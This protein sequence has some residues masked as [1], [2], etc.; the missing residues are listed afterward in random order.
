MYIATVPNRS[1]PPAIL[2]RESHR[3][4]KRVKT[5]TLSNIS[6]WPKEKIEGLRRVLHGE[7]VVSPE[8]AFEIKRSLPHGHVVAVLGTLRRLGLEQL[9][10]RKASRERSLTVSMVVSRIIEPRSKLATA[11]GI[12]EET[13]F[14]SL[15]EELDAAS[16]DENELYLA[17]DWILQSQERIEN[18]L[19]KRHLKSGSLVLYDVT[20]TYF[21]G[22][23]CPLAKLG[24]S[25]DGKKDKLQIVIGLLTNI[26]GC[27]CAVEVFPGNTGDPSTVAAQIRKTK[28]RFLLDRVILVGDRGMIT[29][30]RLQKDFQGVD[31]LDWI[32][33]M[34]SPAIAK[35]FEAGA[36]Q[37]SLFDERDLAEITHPDYP[38]ERLIVCRNPI[39]A[40]ERARK[41][42]DLLAATERTLAKIKKAT[43]RQNRPLRGKDQ[44]ALRVGRDIG[45]YKVQKHFRIKITETSLYYRRKTEKINAEAALDGFYVIRT[46]VPKALLDSE[47]TV[48]SYKRL[49]TVERAFRSLKTVDLKIR[50]IF[51]HTEDR[52]RSHVFICMLAYYVE[53]HMRQMLAPILF[54]DDDKETAEKIRDSIVAPAQRSPRS[55]E[56]AAS[57]RTD[58]DFPV[59]SFQTLIKDLATLTKNQVQAKIDGAPTFI[60]YSTPTRLQQ[61]AFDLLK[62]SPGS[63]RQYG[64]DG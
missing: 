5:K 27:P 43:R 53:W 24:L 45:R 10:D 4:G 14:S 64:A 44:I 20:S 52:V 11:R 47:G 8:D 37:T 49:S 16:V 1:S 35:L 7:T 51:H 19:A 3:E 62:I 59:H 39:L 28:E 33:A 15:G 18:A 30:A 17:M 50:P 29:E 23:T 2:L 38:G 13:A 58:D 61:R 12:A 22:K 48:A 6:H 31:G 25:R 36:I 21:E 57:K 32:T 63:C 55:G 46:S 42:E 60:Q 56:K 41:R 26:D 40:E 34:R 9:M 54:D